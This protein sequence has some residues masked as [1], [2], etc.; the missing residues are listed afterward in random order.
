MITPNRLEQS[1]VRITSLSIDK[2]I[3][4]QVF[5]PSEQHTDKKEDSL[6]LVQCL[7]V[8]SEVVV[9]S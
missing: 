4:G 9:M 5:S 3:Q 1:P 7:D 2:Q 8:C 6:L